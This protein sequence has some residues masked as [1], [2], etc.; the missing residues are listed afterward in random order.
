MN[1]KTFSM[2]SAIVLGM[3]FTACSAQNEGTNVAKD[4]NA[5]APVSQQQGMRVYIDPVTGKPTAP[6]PGSVVTQP[7]D[8][9]HLSTSSQGLAEEVVPGKGVRLNLQGRFQSSTTATVGKDGKLEIE[10]HDPSLTEG[11]AVEEGK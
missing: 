5:E 9:G 3:G 2:L 11:S 1:K 4:M 6:P 7:A 8:G 10:H